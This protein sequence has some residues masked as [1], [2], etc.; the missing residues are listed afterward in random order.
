MTSSEINKRIES[1]RKNVLLKIFQ[2][3]Y[4]QILM[5]SD[6]GIL[7]KV[8][9]EKFAVKLKLLFGVQIWKKMDFV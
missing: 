3:I 2:K 6:F 1:L 4:S 8:L 9:V 5:L 7:S